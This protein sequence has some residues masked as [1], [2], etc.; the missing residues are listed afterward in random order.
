MYDLRDYIQCCIDVTNTGPDLFSLCNFTPTLV[1]HE[2][3]GGIGRSQSLLVTLT[4]RTW[5]PRTMFN[6]RD[7]PSLTM[8]GIYTHLL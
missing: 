2:K 4:A 7:R 1:T 5:G 3:V 8:L 6:A